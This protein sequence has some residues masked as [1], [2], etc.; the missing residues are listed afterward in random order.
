MYFENTGLENTRAD[1]QVVTDIMHKYDLTSEGAWDY[2]R[3]TFDRK[4]VIREGVYYLRV[5]GFAV[6]GDIDANDAMVQ[7]MK[8]VLGKHYYPHGIEYGEDEVFPEHLVKTCFDVLNS[9]KAD[10]QEFE[11]RV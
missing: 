5:F 3:V 6:N 2:E 11:V 7:L 1:I 9:I 10:L 4:F 8:P